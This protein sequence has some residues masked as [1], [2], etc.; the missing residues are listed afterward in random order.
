MYSSYFTN[1][2][3]FNWIARFMPKL[4]KVEEKIR[5]LLQ[6]Y[7][8][9]NHSHGKNKY[10]CHGPC[11]SGPPCAINPHWE[12][13]QPLG[14]HLWQININTIIK[15][16][17]YFLKSYQCYVTNVFG[18]RKLEVVVWYCESKMLKVI[19]NTLVY[20]LSVSTYYVFLLTL[21]KMAAKE[22]TV[23]MSNS[24]SPIARVT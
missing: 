9:S 15:K 7:H 20:K 16:D 13:H 24:S 21:G 22:H 5:V 19:K 4:K 18:E 3:L 14:E 11:V 8:I 12:S 1:K 23:R 17:T 10:G 6:P 2:Y